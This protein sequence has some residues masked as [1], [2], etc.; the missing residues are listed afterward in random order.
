MVGYIPGLDPDNNVL[1]WSIVAGNSLRYFARF[2]M[3]AQGGLHQ[4]VDNNVDYEHGPKSLLLRVQAT[5]G[6]LSASVPVHITIQDLNERPEHDDVELTI[7]EGVQT[8]NVVRVLHGND[9]EHDILT[10]TI[11]TGNEDGH[12]ALSTVGGSS[13]ANVADGSLAVGG[14]NG[15]D[16]DGYSVVSNV[17]DTGVVVS[18]MSG[19][20]YEANNR[21][22]LVV[23]LTDRPCGCLADP[24]KPCSNEIDG[25][26]PKKYFIY[27]KIVNEQLKAN[28]C[29]YCVDWIIIVGNG[30]L[31]CFILLVVVL[32]FF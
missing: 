12:F 23:R 17:V 7:S 22:H 30:V 14:G 10:Y 26:S 3:D 25:K 8:D 28:I 11:M 19:L 5:D 6:E 15:D 1:T 9:P 4:H 27:K 29:F 16:E 31:F 2:T 13:G 18:T 21:Y 24:G 32:L 20:N